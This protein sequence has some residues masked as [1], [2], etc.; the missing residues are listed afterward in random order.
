MKSDLFDADGK[1]TADG[2]KEAAALIS[3]AAKDKGDFIIGNDAN[4]AV[5][6]L[7][8][9]VT[10]DGKTKDGYELKGANATGAA[11]ATW[12]GVVSYATK[13]QKEAAAANVTKAGKLT[14]QIGDTSDTFNQMDVNVGDMHVSAMGFDLDQDGKITTNGKSISEVNI[15]TAENA[16]E[17]IDVIKNAINYVSSI[18]GDLGAVQNRLEHTAKQPVRDGGEHPGR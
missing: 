13:A 5:L 14:L 10:G 4:S 18:R 8:E 2:L 17:A 11:D 6:K 7:T 3:G 15:K 16:H 1:A 9:R 12:A